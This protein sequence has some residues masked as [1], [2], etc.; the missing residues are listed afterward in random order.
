MTNARFRPAVTALEPRENPSGNVTARVL[1]GSLVVTGDAAD[2]AIVVTQAAP[3]QFTV[4]GTDGTTVNG[5]AAAVTVSGVRRDVRITLN[6][7]AD[8]VRLGTGSASVITVARS[9]EIDGGTGD[10]T[11][12]APAGLTVG[13]DVR[14]TNRAGNDTTTF[15]GRLAVGGDV[16]VSNGDGDA[17][18]EVNPD[19]I[20]GANTVAGDLVIVN[21]T[22]IHI[23]RVVDTNVG[24]DVVFDSGPSGPDGG[25]TLNALFTEDSPTRLRVGGELLFRSRGGSQFVWNTVGNTDVGRDLSF[26]VR[27]SGPSS[28]DVFA[29]DTFAGS[30]T[31]GGDL[32]IAAP[33]AGDVSVNLSGGSSVRQGLVVRG[34]LAVLTGSGADTLSLESLNVR[35]ATVL[36]TD[37]G[38]DLVFLTSSTFDGAFLLGTGGGA[39]VVRIGEREPGISGTTF[40]G[41]TLVELGAGDDQLFLGSDTGTGVTIGGPAVFDGGPGT[42]RLAVRP[43]A[44]PP[45]TAFVR[46]ERSGPD[47]S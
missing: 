31:V 29:Y 40:R 36:A 47:A 15:T 7:G 18:T 8:T 12:E 33:R 24:R 14:V 28:N 32:V 27:G 6:G 1:D 41:P 17:T 4:T 22:G 11:V 45:R 25:I 9:L 46:F 38:N 42:D 2:N 21:G 39:D 16:V 13:R 34:S 44:T 10:N 35:R 5:G 19:D 26:D 3:E 23:N 37:G 20:P 43:A 30:A